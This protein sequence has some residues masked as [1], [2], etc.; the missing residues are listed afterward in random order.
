MSQDQKQGTS[1][2]RE[3]LPQVGVCGRAE[4][5]GEVDGDRHGAGPTTTAGPN[6]VPVAGAERNLVAR[7]TAPDSPPRSKE[8]ESTG[9]VAK[10]PHGKIRTPAPAPWHRIVTQCASNVRELH[11]VPDRK[12]ADRIVRAFRAALLPRKAPGRKP[13]KEVLLATEL[14]TQGW[15]WPRIYSEVFIDWA[16]WSWDKRS[17]K[18]FTLRRAVRSRRRRIR[19]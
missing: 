17:H 10:R 12:T 8:P 15:S 19:Q 6:E 4:E 1:T 5:A 18:K 14:R 7:E 16:K 2:T 9:Q 3:T 13:S 11:G